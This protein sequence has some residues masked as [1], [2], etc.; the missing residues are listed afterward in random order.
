MKVS[1]KFKYKTNKVVNKYLNGV[2]EL[3]QS[4]DYS[5]YYNAQ[6]DVYNRKNKQAVIDNTIISPIANQM[7]TPTGKAINSIGQIGSNI[8]DSSSTLS[9]GK[10]DEGKAV[11]SNALKYGAAGA[12][13]GSA[14]GPIGCVC[15]GTKV[16]TNLGEF[17]NIEDL[18]Q[19]DGIIG[20]DGNSSVT[21]SIVAF[22]EPAKKECLEIETQLGHILRCSVD[23]PIYSSGQGRA[24]RSY[25]NRVRTRIKRYEFIEAQDLVL[26]DNIGLINEIPIWG[27]EDMVDPYLVGLC[28][29]DGSYGFDRG[30]R[31]YSADNSTWGYIE[32]NNLGIQI[33]K[34]SYKHYKKEFRAYK[35]TKGT[36]LFRELGIFAQVKT[37]K[38]LPINIHKYNKD[39]ICKLIA[40]LIDTDGYVTFNPDK[41]R[42][43]TIGFSQSNIELIK[44]IRQQLV[45]L[46]IHS[47]LK[48]YKARKKVILGK[49]CNIK[50]RYVLFIKDKHSVINFYENIPLNI[51][52]KK[53]NLNNLY[54]YV[55]NNR[56]KDHKEISNVTADKIVRI[57]PIGVQDIYNL[58]AGGSHTYVANLI[59]THNT[60]V[61]GAV[62][63]I[64]GGIYGAV[65]SRK[66]N[67]L[68]QQGINNSQAL[69]NYLKSASAN[70]FN[71]NI[72][73]DI[74]SEVTK[75]QGFAKYG[76]SK[77]KMKC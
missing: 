23:H 71:Y 29:G 56:T 70:K 58:E 45:K 3:S 31:L 27:T 8:I 54:N 11:A 32:N 15:K 4:P 42:N 33:S 17:K 37:D 10:Q 50:E 38:R 77:L 7:G 44:E 34:N 52:Y 26:G 63:A 55:V 21:Q 1:N 49:E 19:E 51:S 41:P 13:I 74:N 65:S 20:F 24:K 46:G 14:A 2:Q 6:A 30:V 35:I 36:V 57:T 64:G 75:A 76:K 66:N 22:Q 72:Q 5:S 48:T 61:G 18:K 40:G 53:E 73:G 16:I 67:K 47:S 69:N 62:G 43:A 68:I 39:S 25:V 28:I 59:I 12:S 60:A 9:N